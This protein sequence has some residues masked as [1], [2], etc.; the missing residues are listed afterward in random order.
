MKKSSIFR[1]LA[2]VSLLA[3]PQVATAQPKPA[4]PVKAA[5]PKPAPEVR[6]KPEVQKEI[7]ALRN[8]Y[9][10]YK[11]GIV[12]FAETT[13]YMVKRLKSNEEM[14]LR[15]QVDRDSRTAKAKDIVERAK[16]LQLL[17]QRLA[18]YEKNPDPTWTPELLWR[19]A[20]IYQEIAEELFLYYINRDEKTG[21]DVYEE[22][23]QNI[24]VRARELAKGTVR[25]AEAD[26]GMD[27]YHK[28]AEGNL[29]KLVTLFPKFRDIG[30]V[31][32][33]LARMYEKPP[34]SIEDTDG[35]M[36]A[37]L[38]IASVC[39]NWGFSPFDD[40]LKAF[41]VKKGLET[42]PMTAM[43]DYV[44]WTITDF[45]A[46]LPF[47]PFATCRPIKGNV[48][49]LG[50][51]WATLGKYLSADYRLPFVATESTDQDKL[52]NLAMTKWYSLSAYKQALGPEFRALST[53]GY[54]VYFAG[55]MM[56][57]NEINSALAMKL[58]DMVVALGQ[59]RDENSPHEAAIK[60]IGFLMQEEKFVEGA[61]LDPKKQFSWT[62]PVA[63]ECLDKCPQKKLIAFYKGRENEPHVKRIWKGVA[64][65]FMGF[66]E[67]K[68][69]QRSETDYNFAYDL[70]NYI[71]RKMDDEGGWRYNPDKPLIFWNM[72]SLIEMKVKGVEREIT[73]V[74]SERDKNQLRENLRSWQDKKRELYQF[75][76][77]K[78]F[79]NDEIEGYLAFHQRFLVENQKKNVRLRTITIDKLREDLLGIRQFALIDTGQAM[80]AK[81]VQYGDQAKSA[82]GS[83]K[84]ALAK[85]A[86]DEFEKVVA[87]YT[88]IIR[89]FPNSSLEYDASYMILLAYRDYMIDLAASEKVRKDFIQAT[90]EWGRKVR[91]S[92]LGSK[93]QKESAAI[94]YEVYDKKLDLKIPPPPFDIKDENKLIKYTPKELSADFKNYIQDAFEYMKI[95]PKNDN[96]PV[97]I[98]NIANI[99]LHYEQVDEARKYYWQ[100]L[101]SYCTH[102]VAINASQMLFLTYKFQQAEPGTEA[103]FTAERDASIKK[104]EQKKC[105]GDK[106]HRELMLMISALEFNELVKKAEVVFNDAEKAKADGKNDPK[107]WK[108]ALLMYRQ[109]DGQM[110]DRRP[111]A[112]ETEKLKEFEK[113]LFGVYWKIYT[114]T[115]E[116]G[117]YPGAIEVLHKKIYLDETGRMMAIAH[118]D[119][120]KEFM[121][122]ELAEAAT[123]F[124]MEDLAMKMWQELT[125]VKPGGWRIKKEKKIEVK[126]ESTY[127][128]LAEE[129]LFWIYKAGGPKYHAKTLAQVDRLFDIFR[130]AKKMYNK[131]FEVAENEL[132]KQ[133]AQKMGISEDAVENYY[134]LSS[135]CE[136]GRCRVTVSDKI[137]YYTDVIFNMEQ[138]LIAQKGQSE[139]ASRD[140]I[141]KIEQYE[142]FLDGYVPLAK[143]KT[144]ENESM[145]KARM[146][147]TFRKA[148]Q[149]S[150]IQTVLAKNPD[151][152]KKAAEEYGRYIQEY[153]DLY[154]Q[155]VKAGLD[156]GV[157]VI[158][159]ATALIQYAQ[160]ALVKTYEN[161]FKEKS[162]TEID[163]F[164]K[165]KLAF[166]LWKKQ[167]EGKGEELTKRFA[168]LK[169]DLEKKQAECLAEIQELIGAVQKIQAHQQKPGSVPE[170]ELMAAVSKYQTLN[171][172]YPN[173]LKDLQATGD[174]NKAVTK[175]I[176]ERKDIAQ[177]LKE[178]QALSQAG[179][180]MGPENI[181]KYIKEQ[182]P[183]AQ[184]ALTN[185]KKRF[186]GKSI[187]AITESDTILKGIKSDS[188]D[189]NDI[190]KLIQVMQNLAWLSV[191]QPATDTV[192]IMLVNGRSLDNLARGYDWYKNQK[193]A[194]RKQVAQIKG[195]LLALK[196]LLLYRGIKALE[197]AP[198][199]AMLA[200]EDL[201]NP[202]EVQKSGCTQTKAD[203]LETCFFSWRRKTYY[204]STYRVTL[205]GQAQD[206]AIIPQDKVTDEYN[207]AFTALYELVEAEK[208][209]SA[210]IEEALGEYREFSKKKLRR[211]YQP[212]VEPLSR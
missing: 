46:H 57:Q 88:T 39:A 10:L 195:D 75:A 172:K 165:A 194:F 129:K 70:Y 188:T 101:E 138:D 51:A 73:E 140:M 177:L 59:N 163:T 95:Y 40:D 175:T 79:T 173:F 212:E 148:N 164:E 90:L 106:E 190:G 84:T 47:D 122:F 11:E 56:Y 146:D 86:L 22:E 68:T 99:Y 205:D 43:N 29:R 197:E 145:W 151:K 28:K 98:N 156:P 32:H 6:E 127:R 18:V 104:L 141:T 186:A 30:S 209:T 174:V 5:D 77:N 126:D 27:F 131:E 184:K 132:I 181:K 158:N 123:K 112:K 130:K 109:L 179:E 97:F 65:F 74:K 63:V 14:F 93:H 62:A 13:D 207:Q 25:P 55:L 206:L 176:L 87:Y 60:Y 3:L 110:K 61:D 144:K 134:S 67:N 1:L 58:F 76:V 17:E 38:S 94:I 115:K 204:N 157:H 153:K 178:Q 121:I 81:A 15:A 200:K 193:G 182:L 35:V 12:R 105:G 9:R 210:N 108:E 91:D 34:F 203:E 8:D 37:K 135:S 66:E 202:E 117:D 16:L 159:Y 71:F 85:K 50:T 33:L 161:P 118:Q 137:L 128:V 21:K 7:D 96:S 169:E 150:N 49:F 64:D 198:F 103:T 155:G 208:L 143:V 42:M 201:K 52:Y 185:A 154:D 199:L 44:R 187:P 36:P 2:L 160:N 142:R 139:G 162:T 45:P 80:I 125:V 83:E 113:N 89:D 53:R 24:M 124:F 82:Q 48:E 20:V 78:V 23:Y 167:L 92:H 152:A 69:Y 133:L 170:K 19:T 180:K 100:L 111:D 54:V 114:C 119:G 147:L 189:G 120:Y 31:L 102:S 191:L 72:I 4:A 168:K 41:L 166:D 26:L 183:I 107:K 192:T 196:M 149:W 171:K 136:G 116:L 211:S